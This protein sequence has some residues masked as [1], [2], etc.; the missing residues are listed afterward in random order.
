MNDPDIEEIERKTPVEVRGGDRRRTNL[1]VL[2]ISTT[3]I[4]AI[5]AV[6]YAM[7]YSIWS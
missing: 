1:R 2:L 7:G 6:L 3:A 4:V 5:F